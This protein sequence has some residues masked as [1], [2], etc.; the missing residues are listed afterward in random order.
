MVLSVYTIVLSNRE[1][2]AVE[3]IDKTKRALQNPYIW[4]KVA[5]IN[6]K[7]CPFSK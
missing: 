5:R 4:N 6:K 7:K 3:F 1:L 2:D